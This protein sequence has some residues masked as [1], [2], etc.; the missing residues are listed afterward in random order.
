[1]RGDVWV[2][3][4]AQE[5]QL[6]HW[7]ATLLVKHQ[8]LSYIWWTFDSGIHLKL[9]LSSVVWVEYDL[10]VEIELTRSA[11]LLHD[12]STQ[13]LELIWAHCSTKLVLTSSWHRLVSRS[14]EVMASRNCVGLPQRCLVAEDLEV[15]LVARGCAFRDPLPRLLW[16]CCSTWELV[17]EYW[18]WT[19]PPLYQGLRWSTFLGGGW[20]LHRQV[21]VGLQ[22]ARRGNL[23]SKSVN[24][25]LFHGRLLIFKT[26]DVHFG[27]LGHIEDAIILILW[28]ILRWLF[29]SLLL[30]WSFNYWAWIRNRSKWEVPS[31]LLILWLL[32]LLVL[33]PA[34]LTERKGCRCWELRSSLLLLLFLFILYVCLL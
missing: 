23:L 5:S 28:I 12:V 8:S 16:W 30:N 24:R 33:E 18:I 26:Q 4:V 29:D 15:V 32:A 14:L 17:H 22:Q 19:P 1:L 31:H 3:L 21:Q 6:L 2:P 10:I 27:S 11:V 20:F 13:D 9:P 25:R 7:I 34:W